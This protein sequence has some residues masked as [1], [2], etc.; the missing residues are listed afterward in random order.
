MRV[1][2]QTELAEALQ[3]DAA[4]ISRAVRD[5]GFPPRAPGEGWDVDECREWF[6]ARARAPAHD[7]R[8]RAD[9][10]AGKS[11]DALRR[12]RLARAKKAELEAKKAERDLVPAKEVGELLQRWCAGF[13]D[14]LLA[15]PGRLS[16]RL[17][18]DQLDA[19]RKELL[20][21]LQGL[22]DL[23]DEW[24]QAPKSES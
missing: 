1:R 4:T 17:T 9:S 11:D 14:R 15:I 10:A 19:L 5:P 24:A 20:A 7:D 13:R 6:S 23:R 16:D 22:Y 12:F 18:A 21:T 8:P 3:L 2:K